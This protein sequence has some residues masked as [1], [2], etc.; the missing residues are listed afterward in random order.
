MPVALPAVPAPQ[1]PTLPLCPYIAAALPPVAMIASFPDAVAFARSATWPVRSSAS[2]EPVFVKL[3]NGF[4][5]AN[6]PDSTSGKCN[7]TVPVDVIGFGDSEIPVPAF[8]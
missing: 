1:T 4:G 8:S 3:T 6:G 5:F 2:P 7:A